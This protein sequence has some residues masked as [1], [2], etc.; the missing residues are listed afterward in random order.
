MVGSDYEGTESKEDSD[1]YFD[2]EEPDDGLGPLYRG[3]YS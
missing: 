3:L 2:D 1:S